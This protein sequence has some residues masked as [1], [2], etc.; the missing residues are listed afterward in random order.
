MKFH[1]NISKVQGAIALTRKFVQG[2]GKSKRKIP[3]VDFLVK[4]MV[5]MFPH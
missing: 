2:A 3:R 5:I 4:D 1:V